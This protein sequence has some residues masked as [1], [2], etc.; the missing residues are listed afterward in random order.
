MHE[1]LHSSIQL[2]MTTGGGGYCI[3]DSLD[4]CTIIMGIISKLIYKHC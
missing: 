4:I 2:V 1:L 3:G